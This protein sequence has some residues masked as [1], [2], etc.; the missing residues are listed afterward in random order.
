MKKKL[1][2]SR[3]RREGGEYIKDGNTIEFPLPPWRREICGKLNYPPPK[4][5]RTL[6]TFAGVSEE[7]EVSY[8]G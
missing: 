7:Q 3:S 6:N 2:I 5:K 8:S 4:Q 1:K